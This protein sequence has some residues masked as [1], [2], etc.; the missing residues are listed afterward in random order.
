M[1][2]DYFLVVVVTLVKCH[3]M[4]YATFYI[5]FYVPDVHGLK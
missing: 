4:S 2:L 3:L 1:P 5:D